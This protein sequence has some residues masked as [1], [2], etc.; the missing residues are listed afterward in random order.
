[1][2]SMLSANLLL[3]LDQFIGLLRLRRFSIKYV[4]ADENTDL[5]PADSPDLRKMD[6]GFSYL[7]NPFP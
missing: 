2:L 6:E 4:V 3:L 1:M 7:K 5:S